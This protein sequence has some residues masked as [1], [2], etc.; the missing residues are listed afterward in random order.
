MGARRTSSPGPILSRVHLTSVTLRGFKSFADRTHLPLERGLVAVVGPN[1]SG[2]SNLID[3]LI[4]SLGTLSTRALRAERMED[5]IFVGTSGRQQLGMA[6]VTLMFDNTSRAFPVDFTEV[7]IGRTL[8]RDGASEYTLNGTACRLLDIQDLLSEAGIGR[9]LHAVV[10]QGQVD[11][12]VNGSPEQLRSFV[13]E[14]AGISKHRRRKERA[15]R[16]MEHV[17]ADISRAA[18]LLNEMRRQI[19]PLKSQ[20][21]QALRHREVTTRLRELRVKLLVGELVAAESE[22]SEA[23]SGREKA[24]GELSAVR[25]ELELKRTVRTE[26]E[27]RLE[28]SRSAATGMRRGLD[29]LRAAQ[30]ASLRS[31][32]VLREKVN[33]TPD[34]RRRETLVAKAGTLD[35]QEATVRESLQGVET[36]IASGQADLTQIRTERLELAQAAD[37][38][39]QQ[40]K[41][42]RDELTGIDIESRSSENIATT[43]RAEAQTASER[44]ARS[45]EQI[46]RLQQQTDVVREEIERLDADSGRAGLTV[47]RLE[48]ERKQT[49][50]SI[51]EA[52]TKLRAI[53][54]EAAV[55]AGRLESL[56]VARELTASRR[57]S[58]E[59]LRDRSGVEIGARGILGESITVASGLERA[60]EAV[61]GRAVDALV[62]AGVHLADAIV[63]AEEAGDDVLV[64]STLSATEAR[65][66]VPGAR[67]LASVVEAP[68]WLRATVDALLDDAWLVQEWDEAVRLAATYPRSTF[69]TTSGRVLRPSGVSRPARPKDEQGILGITA[70][71]ERTEEAARSNDSERGRWTT[72]RDRKTSELQRLDEELGQ[73]RSLL[74]ELEGRIAAAADR[75]RE[76]GGE[77]HGAALERD[78]AGRDRDDRLKRAEQ[79]TARRQ[80]L[81]ER[82][83]ELREHEGQVEATAAEAAARLRESDEAMR[84]ASEGMTQLLTEQASLTERLRGLEAQRAELRAE[85]AVDHGPPTDPGDLEAAEQVLRKIELMVERVQTQVRELLASEES[86][87]TQLREVSAEISR[88]DVQATALE[89]RSLRIA[90]TITR[91]DVRAEE[92]GSRLARDFDLPPSQ[93]RTEFQLDEDPTAMRSEESKLDA[94]L[95]R[96]GPVNPLAAEE[97]ITLEERREFLQN[98]VEDLRA[99]RRDLMKLVR[100]ATDRMRELLVDAV[101]DADE[102]F[103]EVAELLFPEGDG[104]LRLVGESED[105]L[106]KGIEIEVRLGRKGHRRLAFLS[107]GERALAGL[108]FLFALH[109]A[110]PTPFLVLD[111]VDAPLDDANLGRFLRLL[112]S[113]RTKTQVLVVTHQKR[114]MQHADTLIG[115]TLNPDGTSKVLTQALH[116]HA[117]ARTS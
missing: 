55:L 112:D 33:A 108:G 1:G 20:A 75:L 15:L 30:A 58:A 28:A 44:F 107:G 72:N 38:A 105:P 76:L 46:S 49:A 61:L 86:I 4:W 103:R 47:E 24:T 31:V 69:V 23:I 90:E 14:A 117:Q 63:K 97:V 8:Y 40:A 42:I 111:E 6:Q 41:A 53:E 39:A 83:V 36:Q 50:G 21:E 73:A 102:R 25:R 109:L 101:K 106:E 94:E 37:A 60:V 95:R 18:D 74:A 7:Q 115:V 80:E 96:M 82:A 57:K 92:I 52:E 43:A 12:I 100:A 113:L 48:T 70:A 22:R 34:A 114:T 84:T 89:P 71:I 81:S 2:K 56:R 93:A 59:S 10:A 88:L 64:T 27:S 9:E 77:E 79:A 32:L 68:G 17:E 13:E 19:N 29:H 16:K 11:E 3:A 65:A 104:R 99:S 54:S 66:S 51:Q 67:A 110:R 62:V 5:V 78:L 87:E 26:A 35:S 116:E 85:E 98:Q 91:C 45:S